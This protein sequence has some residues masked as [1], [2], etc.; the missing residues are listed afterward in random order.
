MQ[1]N[2]DDAARA[3]MSI[4]LFVVRP[5]SLLLLMPWI[6]TVLPIMVLVVVGAATVATILSGLVRRLD[7]IFDAHYAVN[8][9]PCG[10]YR[11]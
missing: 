4:M 6:A 3:D 11:L 2:H 8:V 5:P 10:D 1:V 7:G 9:L